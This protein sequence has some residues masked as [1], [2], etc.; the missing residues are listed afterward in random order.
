[1]ARHIRRGDLCCY[2]SGGTIVQKLADSGH[3]MCLRTV[4]RA[5]DDLQTAGLEIRHCSF[6]STYIFPE[7]RQ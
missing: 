3:P 5:I 1:M 6:T 7:D 4:R 2:V